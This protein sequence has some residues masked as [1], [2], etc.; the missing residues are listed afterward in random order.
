MSNLIELIHSPHHNCTALSFWSHSGGPP[1][2]G[3]ENEVDRC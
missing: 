1:S 3:P 2:G